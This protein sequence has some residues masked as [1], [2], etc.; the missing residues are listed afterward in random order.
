M[1]WC[2]LVTVVGAVAGGDAD[3]G[4]CERPKLDEAIADTVRLRGI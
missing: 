3:V 4:I 1:T 2:K